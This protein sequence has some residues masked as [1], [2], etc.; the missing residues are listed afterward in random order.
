MVQ[1]GA[2]GARISV[3]RYRWQCEVPTYAYKK[4]CVKAWRQDGN[5]NEAMLVDFNND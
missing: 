4:I 3:P 5:L 1:A 2:I